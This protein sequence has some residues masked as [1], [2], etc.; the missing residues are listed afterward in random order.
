MHESAGNNALQCEACAFSTLY[1]ESLQRHVA[2]LHA[3]DGD[4]ARH[5]CTIC[6]FKSAYAISLQRHVRS[7]HGGG[8]E[9][10]GPKRMRFDYKKRLKNMDS[11]KSEEKWVHF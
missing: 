6:E 10:S 5:A 7:Q 9:E 2:N 3:K 11:N 8:E 1:P 4:K